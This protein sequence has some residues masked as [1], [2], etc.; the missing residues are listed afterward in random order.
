MKAILKKLNVKKEQEILLLN[1]PNEFDRN[2]HT[3]EGI[4]ITESLVQLTKTDYALLFITDENQLEKQFETLEIKLK[5]DATLW[6]AY[7]SSSKALKKAQSWQAL[8]AHCFEEVEATQI[9]K[10]WNAKRFRKLEY[11]HCTEKTNP[12]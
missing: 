5:D 8:A 9:N 3:L 11:L 12:L 7:P 4:T 10:N 2:F 6:V 1:L